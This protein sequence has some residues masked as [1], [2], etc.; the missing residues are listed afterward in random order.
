M[1]CS[2]DKRAELMKGFIMKNFK[3]LMAI[4]AITPVLTLAAAPYLTT[5]LTAGG[6]SVEGK[7]D[8]GD[9]TV[10]NTA[11][12]L[13]VTYSIANDLMYDKNANPMD[14]D[15]KW[16]IDRTQTDVRDNW[17]DIPQ[18]KGKHG[19]NPKVGKFAYKSPELDCV[20]F[21]SEIIT[22]I[23]GN[24][25]DVDIAAHADVKQFS[26]GPLDEEALDL[27]YPRDV[28]M[29]VIANFGPNSYF[30]INI[31]LD[32]NPFSL[33]GIHEGWCVCAKNPINLNEEHPVEAAL[34]GDSI[35]G[36]CVAHPENL[37]RVQYIINHFA[38]QDTIPSTGET[39]QICDIQNAIW[40]AM[41]DP[42]YEP[43]LPPAE[44]QCKGYYTQENVDAIV[45]EAIANADYVPGCDE[46]MLVVLVPEE[47][48]V[49][50]TVI[51][52]PVPCEGS[53][54]DET[55]WGG[56]WVPRGGQFTFPGNN[57]AYYFPYTIQ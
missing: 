21:Y 43:L 22:P 27:L 41:E 14:N 17:E 25:G 5:D 40:T 29:E 52:T 26:Y 24:D 30:D 35:V 12:E 37:P 4:T 16:C 23:P 33:N 47:E 50:S 10:T 57:W 7:V 28:T 20:P 45:A 13:N 51:D 53:W 9:V 34:I 55:A 11:T 46:K 54:G 6:G 32:N 42:Y 2:I 8:I 48:G 36:S 15:G 3:L 19:G 49:Q 39:V 18:T 1:F 56:T 31:T 44:S 38:Y